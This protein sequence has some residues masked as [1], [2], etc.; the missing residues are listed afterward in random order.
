MK[1]EIQGHL[2]VPKSTK[3]QD[4]IA[5]A[6]TCFRIEM[7]DYSMLSVGKIVKISPSRL[8]FWVLGRF[9]LMIDELKKL[10][11]VIEVNMRVE[12]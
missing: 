5:W 12:Y 3:Q 1:I 7:K 2:N 11:R 9:D 4:V 6:N 10:S 8:H